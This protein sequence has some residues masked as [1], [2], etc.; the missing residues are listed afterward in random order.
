[1]TTLS[2]DLLALAFFLSDRESEGES[3]DIFPP[4]LGG[5]AQGYT[6]AGMA[7]QM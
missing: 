5:K 4:F 7:V 6:M 3:A 2:C 1:M